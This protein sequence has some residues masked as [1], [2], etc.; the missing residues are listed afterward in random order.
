MHVLYSLECNAA[1][2]FCCIYKIEPVRSITLSVLNASE[3][4]LPGLKNI[5]PQI[6]LIKG[7]REGKK[8]ALVLGFFTLQQQ[9][10]EHAGKADKIL[11][12]DGPVWFAIPRE[13]PKSS[14]AILT[15]IPVG[16]YWASLVLNLCE[17]SN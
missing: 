5:D 16:P 3:P 17:R 4:F 9:V 7:F 1:G 8:G 10:D 13:L 15:A 2:Y 14:P 12:G 6:K 11:E